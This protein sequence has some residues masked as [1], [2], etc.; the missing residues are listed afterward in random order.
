M[1]VEDPDFVQRV[2]LNGTSYKFEYDFLALSRLERATGLSFL[3]IARK[4]AD[5]RFS[6]DLHLDLMQAALNGS[7]PETWTKAA[8]AKL[9]QGAGRENREKLSDAALTAFSAM[10]RIEFTD[11][12]AGKAGAPPAG[13]QPGPTGPGSSAPRP[14]QG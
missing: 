4:L 3:E 1:P 6:I 10:F 8:V 12:T 7:G 14:A 5:R 13:P 9:Y 2:E 11:G